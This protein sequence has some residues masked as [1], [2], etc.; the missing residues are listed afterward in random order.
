LRIF[1]GQTYNTGL[2]S[3][4]YV[5][6]TICFLESEP[7]TVLLKVWNQDQIIFPDSAFKN[8]L[9]K[10]GVDTSGDGWIS[11]AEAEAVTKLDINGDMMW[12]EFCPVGAGNIRIIKGIEA[13][14]NLDTFDCSGNTILDTINLSSNT[15]LKYLKCNPKCYSGRCRN[16][17]KSLNVSGCLA[18][19]YLDCGENQLTSL[20]VTKNTGLTSLW[21]NQN[22]LNSLDLCNNDS[23]RYLWIEEMPTLDNVFV[24]EAPFPPLGVD[25]STSGS[26]NVVFLDCTVTGMAESLRMITSFIPIQQMT[27]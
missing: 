2:T 17:I 24:W 3:T 1:H 12:A 27:C 18:L 7:D 20:D 4:L 22:Q 9:I 19:T 16:G 5:K 25:V 8:A 10:Q 15:S 11:Y 23:I 6:H 21:C 14:M 13:F 26:P